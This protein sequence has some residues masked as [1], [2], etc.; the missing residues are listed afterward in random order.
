[1]TNGGHMTGREARALRALWGFT[2]SELGALIGVSHNVVSRYENQP[3]RT[4][5]RTLIIA[6]PCAPCMTRA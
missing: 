2:Q 5:P 4:L 1:M 6:R 3:D